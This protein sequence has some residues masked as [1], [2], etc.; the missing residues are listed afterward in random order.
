MINE[1]SRGRIVNVLFFDE[2]ENDKDDDAELLKNCSPLSYSD[3]SE[4]LNWSVYKEIFKI[5][6]LKKWSLKYYLKC[7]KFVIFFEIPIL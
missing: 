1:N 3:E 2:S 5:Y 7:L 4:N 6:K